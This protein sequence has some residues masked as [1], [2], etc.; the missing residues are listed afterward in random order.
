MVKEVSPRL[1]SAV[2]PESGPLP[3][4]LGIGVEVS[5]RTLSEAGRRVEP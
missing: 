2:R 3:L 5:G 1:R 4:E